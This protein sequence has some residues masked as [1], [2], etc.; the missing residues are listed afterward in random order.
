[1]LD[2]DKINFHKLNGL[3]PACVQ[4]HETLQVLMIGFMN[5][6]AL[7]QT[8][9]TGKVTFWSRSKNRLWV[10]G[11]TSGN[12]LSVIDCV[13]DCDDDSLLVYAKPHGPTCH[14]GTAS[15]FQA[16]DA[17]I[18]TLC[19]LIKLNNVIDDRHQHPKSG[20]YTTQLFQSGT[21]RIAQKVGEEGVEVALAAVAETHYELANEAADLLFHLLVLLKHKNLDLKTVAHILENR[22]RKKA[23]HT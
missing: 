1:M 6:Q 16:E 4:D 23:I 5:R 3:I 15:C 18:P 2:I 20:S 11:E 21:K 8:I 22:A 13:I 7:E 9:A 14:K 17:D 10:K 12:F 19:T